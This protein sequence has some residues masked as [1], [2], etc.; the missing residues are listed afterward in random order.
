MDV[1]D[2]VAL[3]CER[4]ISARNGPASLYEDALTLLVLAN[5][6]AETKEPRLRLRATQIVEWH[7]NPSGEP[8]FSVM[9][10][11]WVVLRVGPALALKMDVAGLLQRSHR[12][13]LKEWT[14]RMDAFEAANKTG[15]GASTDEV[16]SIRTCLG[17]ALAEVLYLSL[18]MES[19]R[20]EMEALQAR[21]VE[22]FGP[23]AYPPEPWFAYKETALTVWTAT[24][25]TYPLG[26]HRTLPWA[27]QL[28]IDGVNTIWPV[29]RRG[30]LESTRNASE[31][32]LALALT[33]VVDSPTEYR[34]IRHKVLKHWGPYALEG[35]V[36]IEHQLVYALAVLPGLANPL[37]S[38]V[39][40]RCMGSLRTTTT[41]R[42]TSLSYWLLPYAL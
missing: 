1:V 7:E 26:H 36:S 15:E 38:L 19:E 31:L 10:F 22:E 40:T 17:P 32:Y 5:L 25:A 11:A 39:R 37:R 23:R 41:D 13:D 34:Q 20:C 4:L 14:K 9:L 42:C 28:R 30:Y 6:F 33:V 18:G 8:H 24:M 29:S 35:T 12:N 16:V 27:R 2:A 3:I 21:V